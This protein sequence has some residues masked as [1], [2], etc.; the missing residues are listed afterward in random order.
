VGFAWLCR[1]SSLLMLL[2][3]VVLSR[4]LFMAYHYAPET[5]YMVEVYPPMIAACG[6]TAAALWVYLKRVVG[7]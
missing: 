4:T 7:K 2:L 1:R 5:R 3:L 6:V